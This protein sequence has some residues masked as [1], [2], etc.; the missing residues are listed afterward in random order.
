MR[1]LDYFGGYSMLWCK[2][3]NYKKDKYTLT[4]DL[5]FNKWFQQKHINYHDSYFPFF[6]LN[7]RTEPLNKSVWWNAGFILH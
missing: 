6:A 1:N 4:L 3:H 7:F 5:N 2:E